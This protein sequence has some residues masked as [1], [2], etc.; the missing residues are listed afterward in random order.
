MARS[1]CRNQFTSGGRVR[2]GK[3]IQVGRAVPV[4]RPWTPPADFAGAG[5]AGA[6][7]RVL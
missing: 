1:P 2:Q 3:A 7:G 4:E 6:R 5:L